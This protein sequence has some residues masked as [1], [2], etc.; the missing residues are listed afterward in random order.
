MELLWLSTVFLTLSPALA[1]SPRPGSPCSCD[2]LPRVFTDFDGTI[3]V[4]NTILNFAEAVYA[5]TPANKRTL[6]PL[7][8]L[9]A[10]YEANI[11]KASQEYGSQDTIAQEVAFESSTLRRNVDV[12]LF[13]RVAASGMISYLNSSILQSA[14]ETVVLRPDFWEWAVAASRCGVITVLSNNFSTQWLRLVLRTTYANFLSA[15]NTTHHPTNLADKIE[16]YCPEILTT[17]L[18]TPSP[19]DHPAP[20]HDGGDKLVLLRR[21]VRGDVSRTLYLGDSVDDLPPLVGAGHG[22][23]MGNDTGLMAMLTKQGATLEPLVD[24]T[25]LHAE[26]KDLILTTGDWSVLASIWEEEEK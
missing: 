14:A 26:G 9:L 2:E 20:L 15:N 4:N 11:T 16:V 5:A 3:S 23:L 10:E 13:D 8:S 21:L 22:V 7:A 19:A 6:P 18:V 12:T 24:E 25:S 17:Q 1:F